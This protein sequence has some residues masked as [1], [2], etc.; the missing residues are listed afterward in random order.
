MLTWST[1][2]D[3]DKSLVQ[4]YMLLLFGSDIWRVMTREEF[5]LCELV[6]AAWTLLLFLF[7]F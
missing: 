1:D 4:E 2:F 7:V 6:L 5:K 3:V